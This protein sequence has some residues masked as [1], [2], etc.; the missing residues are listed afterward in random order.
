MIRR[1][2]RSTRT[3]TLFPYTTLFR[4]EPRRRLEGDRRAERP[5]VAAVD[6]VF[7]RRI[8]VIAAALGHRARDAHRQHVVDQRHVEHREPAAAV[9]IADLALDAPLEPAE[10]GLGRDRKRVV[11]GSR[12][13]VGVAPGGGGMITKKK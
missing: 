7:G 4:S 5:E 11:S 12:V 3:D 8:I 9:V 13:S 6:A 2:P 10:L 1:P